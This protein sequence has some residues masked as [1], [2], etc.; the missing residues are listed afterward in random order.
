MIGIYKIINT[1]NN[2][3]YVGS[4]TNINTRWNQHRKSL[5]SNTHHSVKLQRSYNKYGDVFIYELII[6]CLVEELLTEEQYYIELLDSYDNGYNSIPTAGS[7]LGMKHTDE[8]KNKLR[9][10]S[11]GN[12]NRLGMK[13]TDETKLKISIKLKD[14]PLSDETKLKMSISKLGKK[15]TDES[16]LKMREAQIGKK[17]TDETKLKMSNAKLGK[18]Q[19][20]EVIENRVKK[21]TG[22]KRTEESKMKISIKLTG[23][24][25]GPMSDEHKLKVSRF[26]KIALIS[27]DG[28]IIKQYDSIKECS[29]ELEIDH[30]RISDVVTGKKESYKGYKFIYL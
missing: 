2:K 3:V 25:R 6:E 1:L 15:H 16:K 17:H 23:I 10:S 11:T 28:N 24:K 7:N 30:R 22:K 19:S 4:S 5:C 27:D 20:I 13:H 29:I 14:K 18:K 26:K 8:T 12:T 9:E 21:N